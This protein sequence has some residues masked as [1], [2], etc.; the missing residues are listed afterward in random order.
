MLPLHIQARP[1]KITFR[2]IINLCGVEFTSI[3][4]EGLTQFSCKFAVSAPLECLSEREKNLLDE[5]SDFCNSKRPNIFVDRNNL[6]GKP[7]AV[8]GPHNL[9]FQ[10]ANGPLGPTHWSKLFKQCGGWDP[11]Y[12][13]MPESMTVENTGISVQLRVKYANS[14]QAKIQGGP[15]SSTYVLDSIH[16]HWGNNDHKGSEHMINGKSYPMEMHAV[17]LKPHMTLEQAMKLPDGIVVVAYIFE[18][19]DTCHVPIKYIEESFDLIEMDVNTAQ[20]LQNMFEINELVEPFCNGYVTYKGS[21]T[22]P[23]CS[24][25]VTW[26]VSPYTIGLSKMQLQSFRKLYDSSKNLE[27]NFRP[28]QPLNGRTVHFVN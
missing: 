15:M 19:E 14:T 24:E 25:S 2:L 4:V 11:V 27:N 8:S 16:F 28:V 9:N 20:P 13:S 1:I 23:P 7:Q 18:I 26:I 6:L 12:S 5:N 10:Y 3:P 22:T 21:L 17:H